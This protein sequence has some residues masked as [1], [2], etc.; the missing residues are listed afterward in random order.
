VAVKKN[1]IGGGLVRR[2]VGWGPGKASWR[3]AVD[4]R[5]AWVGGGGVG[6]RGGGSGGPAAGKGG[7]CPGA[8]PPEGY[9]PGGSQVN[10]F[11]GLL[12]HG[13][14]LTPGG[15]PAGEEEEREANS[16][17]VCERSQNK[18]RWLPP[19]GT[20]SL[21]AGPKK[22]TGGPCLLCDYRGGK[23]LCLHMEFAS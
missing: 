2:D 9:P 21:G 12:R 14:M 23:A 1:F 22:G 8:N 10:S 7:V 13:T 19:V 6:A 5:A 3:F 16:P 20:G 18:L 17:E 15:G 4:V 11:A